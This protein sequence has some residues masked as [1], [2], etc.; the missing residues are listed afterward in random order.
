MAITLTVEVDDKGSAK[1]TKFAD[2]TNKNLDKVQKKSSVLNKEMG[3]G[4]NKVGDAAFGASK[5]IAKFAVEIAAISFTA[6]AAGIAL[7][8]KEAGDLEQQLDFV[9]AVLKDKTDPGF[10]ELSETVLQLGRDTAWMSTQVAEG[11]EQLAKAGFSTQ[12]IISALPATL[13]LATAGT[14]NLADAASITASTLRAFGIQAEDT[15]KVADVLAATATNTNTTIQ[16]IGESMKF[17]A[18]LA[19]TAGISLQETAA[20]IGL[21]GNV[22]IDA[23]MAGTTLRAAIAAL[24]TPSREQADLMKELGLNVVTSTGQITSLND[25]IMQ[26]KDAGATTGEVLSLFG[27]RG[28]PGLAALISM[29]DDSL[30][31]FTGTLNEA[32]GTVDDVATEKLDN[33][34]GQMTLLTSATQNMMIGLGDPLLPMFSDFIKVDVIPT[35]QSMAEWVT[36]NR[37]KIEEFGQGLMGFIRITGEGMSSFI[38]FM[39]STGLPIIATIFKT[40]GDT[41]G[42]LSA[43]IVTVIDTLTFMGNMINKLPGPVKTAVK[44][45]L[46]FTNVMTAVADSST[47][48]RDAI[49]GFGVKSIEVGNSL[50][51]LTMKTSDIS[52][53]LI[54]AA[55]SAHDTAKAEKDLNTETSTLIEMT[56]GVVPVVG[57][58]AS[59]FDDATESMMDYENEMESLNS[60]TESAIGS[61]NDNI[62]SLSS[63][64]D[65]VGDSVKGINKEVESGLGEFGKVQEQFQAQIKTTDLMQFLRSITPGFVAERTNILTPR[66][67]SFQDGGIVPGS[68]SEMV[69][70]LLHGGEEV[71]SSA[72]RGGEI[73]QVNLMLDGSV[74]ASQIVDL[75]RGNVSGLKSA[76]EKPS[77]N[78]KNF[79]Q[80]GA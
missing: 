40:I 29:G 80:V 21:L 31:N 37:D 10:Q 76:I 61:M 1:I 8:T 60:I 42:F 7:V 55:N 12:E 36:S 30:K 54:Q 11:A 13:N 3:A 32:G 33:F 23:S 46:P 57:E 18:P 59:G 58:M 70:A 2:T 71:I 4:F 50:S 35:I 47:G 77:A 64:W 53:G 44:V 74:L 65:G 49:E 9:G 16:T 34:K 51:E 28:G 69:P 39:Q 26:L 63:S 73:I 62:N 14:L 78:I 27:K 56:E 41:L 79:Q 20:A 5:A 45:M 67:P 38:G 6:A 25:V 72:D 66:I 75:K 15:S 68:P 17:V 22:G 24:L 52:F 19:R 43:V 48:A